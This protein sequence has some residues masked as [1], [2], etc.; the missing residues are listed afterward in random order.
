M[1]KD[2]IRNSAQ[3][4]KKTK[5]QEP[6]I[7]QVAKFRRNSAAGENSQVAKFCSLRNFAILPYAPKFKQKPAKINTRKI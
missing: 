7:M 6:V 3:K 4:Q 5:K 2:K 1:I